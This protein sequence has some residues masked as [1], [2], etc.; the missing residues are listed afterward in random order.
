M[1]IK[2]TILNF[3]MRLIAL[4]LI[5]MREK[6]I[7]RLILHIFKYLCFSFPGFLN[8]YPEH[9]M[10]TVYIILKTTATGKNFTKYCLFAVSANKD[11]LTIMFHLFFMLS[12]I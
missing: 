9:Q 11:F 12:Q 10:L 2:F 4:Y 1:K 5:L 8:S 7:L 3:N 6:N